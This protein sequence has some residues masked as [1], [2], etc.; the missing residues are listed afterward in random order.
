MA[1]SQEPHRIQ[2]VGGNKATTTPS[3]SVPVLSAP[4]TIE[5][6]VN[7]LILKAHRLGASDVHL[8]PNPDHLL[9]RARIDGVLQAIDK[10][11]Q[12]SMK[13]AITRL[14]IMSGLDNNAS[15]V[16]TDGR[17]PFG[18]FEPQAKEVDIRS[19]FVATFFG[20]K[21]VLRIVDHSK[22]KLTLDEL[23]FTEA[24]ARLYQQI[25]GRPSG[26]V[27]Q[28]GPQGCG[29][30]TTAYAALK[31]PPRPNASVVTVEEMVEYVLPGIT[32]IQLNTDQGLTYARAVQGVLRQDP[33]VILIGEIRDAETARVAVEA[34]M[35]GRLVL[36]TLHATS[37]T[38]AVVR[39]TELGFTRPQV[40]H[41][42]AGVVSQ[43]L[44]RRLCTDCREKIS[45][46]TLIRSALMLPASAAAIWKP[47]ACRKCGNKGFRGRVA[48]MEVVAFTDRLREAA[49]SGATPTQLD[50]MAISEGTV[51]LLRDAVDK[52]LQG[53]TAVEEILRTLCGV[54]VEDVSAI[55]EPG[56]MVNF[57]KTVRDQFSPAQVPAAAAASLQ[58]HSTQSFA[59]PAPPPRERTRVAPSGSFPAAMLDEAPRQSMVSRSHEE[60]RP[61][62]GQYRMPAPE[63]L[64][65][66]SQQYAPPQP[67]YAP[68]Q[69]AQPSYVPGASQSFGTPG[70]RTPAQQEDLLRA[71]LTQ[72][73][74]EVTAQLAR[75]AANSAAGHP[76]GPPGA[77]GRVNPNELLKQLQ[78]LQRRLGAQPPS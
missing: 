77:T 49:A 51:P 47:K 32:Q 6:T 48:V 7:E 23:G 43:R 69:H 54:A 53:A 28:V 1:G 76:S 56:E 60:P 21:A 40:A 16:P 41:A 74:P 24:N 39:L 72:L 29:K 52:I 15:Q 11:P 37:A 59:V 70:A 26:L 38:N 61:P 46:S 45:P 65:R 18:R 36:S 75:A 66:P 8:E 78:E 2:G 10:V 44:V 50:A 68:P 12:D 31:N 57:L 13:Q 25:V 4:S 19:T 14:K 33:D 73:P 20:E 9:V 62:S 3:G 5:R 22:L 35:S 34:A 67:Q 55:T 63:E 71:L 30:T 17:F 64:Y 27:L 58:P 42:L